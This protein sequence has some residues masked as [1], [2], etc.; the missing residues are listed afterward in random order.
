MKGLKICA[1]LVA[2]AFASASAFA[3]CPAAGSATGC[4]TTIVIG[5][6]GTLTVTPVAGSTPYDGSDD[7]LIGITN[8]SGGSVSSIVL[9]GTGNGGGLFAFDG[10]GI[11]QY[12]ANTN[13]NSM[14][15]SGTNGYAYG[16]PISYFTNVSAD[17]ATG[18]VNFIGG[19]GDGQS[20]FFSLESSIGTTTITPGPVNGGGGGAVTPEPSTFV[21]LGT[22][23]LSL[24]G[25]LRRRFMSR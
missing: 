6:G 5:P 8:H 14:D 20:T 11:D 3:Q 10:D 17:Q 12:L 2:G 22:G 19:L 24:A 7:N 23:A 18:T 13:P 21:L 15:T 16:G 25:G 4:D 1:V 9:S